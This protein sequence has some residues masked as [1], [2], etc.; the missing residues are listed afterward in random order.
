MRYKKKLITL[1]ETLIV[2]G[3]LCLVA[4]VVGLNVRNLFKEQRFHTEVSRVLDTLRLAQ[5]LMLI[6]GSDSHVLFTQEPS[7]GISYKIHLEKPIS[8]D[9]IRELARPH[10]PLKAIQWIAFEDHQLGKSVANQFELHFLSGGSVMSQG[11][12]ILSDGSRNGDLQSYIFLPGYPAPL[13]NGKTAGERRRESN[14]LEKLS[15]LTHRE[16][17]TRQQKDGS[18]N[19]QK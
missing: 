14:L 11:N 1:I 18:E 2:L 13:V 4:G 10:P 3:I 16:I 19:S 8:K 9:W 6:A 5:D 7:G 12:L 15:F 17:T